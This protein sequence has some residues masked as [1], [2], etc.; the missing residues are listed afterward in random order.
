MVLGLLDQLQTL[1]VVSVR[2]T[3]VFNIYGAVRAAAL[4][5]SKA[6]DRVWHAG[7]LHKLKSYRFQVGYLAIFC[8]SY[9]FP[10]P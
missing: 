7:L 5:T 9:T 10:I 3:R 8:L 6:R 2:I 1:T 4:D